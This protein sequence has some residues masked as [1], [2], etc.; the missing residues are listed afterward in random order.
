ML[1]Y[2]LPWQMACEASMLLSNTVW[3][4]TSSFT[5]QS[6]QVDHW[7]TKN[8]QGTHWCKV[9]VGQEWSKFQCNPTLSIKSNH[10][11]IQVVLGSP[12][13][14]FGCGHCGP[15][16]TGIT[17]SSSPGYCQL[18]SCRGEIQIGCTDGLYGGSWESRSVIRTF[19][20]HFND[21]ITESPT[22]TQP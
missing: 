1:M 7:L 18:L 14:C 21:S 19:H 11:G 8:L 4:M 17:Q 5:S 6:G 12:A 10:I 20:A 2:L 9:N 15:H 3:G 13:L 22:Y 16:C